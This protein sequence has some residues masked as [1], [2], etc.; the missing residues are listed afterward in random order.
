MGDYSFAKDAL[1]RA[2]TQKRT[3][4]AVLQTPYRRPPKSAERTT[5]HPARLVYEEGPCGIKQP[6]A[7]CVP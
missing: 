2:L 1:D 5:T 6:Y 7:A 3:P 4:G